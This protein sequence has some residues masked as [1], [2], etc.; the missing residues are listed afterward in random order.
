MAPGNDKVIVFAVVSPGTGRHIAHFDK[1]PIRYVGRR[2]AEIIADGWRNIQP[3]SM[4]EV[5][6]R[7]F[8][9]K[10]V[11]EMIGAKWTAIFP[12]RVASAVAFANCDP[13]I[14]THRLAGPCVDL[15]E[16]RDDE[17]SFWFELTAGDVVVR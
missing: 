4:V 11:L 3:S 6:F 1:L 9:L 15:L 8:I 12:L 2:E 5:R 10:N 14:F 7:P 17:R 13:M 16:P